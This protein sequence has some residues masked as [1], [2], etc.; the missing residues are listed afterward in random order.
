MKQANFL[1]CADEAPDCSNN[2]K[3]KLPIVLR[4]VDASNT[5]QE[6]FIEFVLCD[7]CTTGVAIAD[8]IL[9]ALEDYGLDCSFLRGQSYDGAGNMAGKYRGAAATIQSTYSKAVYVH[10]AAHN[11][12]LCV[13]AACHVQMVKNLMETMVQISLFF[14]KLT[15]ATK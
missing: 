7:T 8:K 4:Y 5:I 14:L 12:N 11:L 6:E 13:V 2:L 10:C 1:I 3:E 15:K 9:K